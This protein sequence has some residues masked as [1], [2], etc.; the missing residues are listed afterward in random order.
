MVP[1]ARS[2]AQIT[3]SLTSAVHDCQVQRKQ[4]LTHSA[5]EHSAVSHRLLAQILKLICSSRLSSVILGPVAWPLLIP[6]CHVLM[7]DFLC[8]WDAQYCSPVDAGQV[9]QLRSPK[10]LGAADLMCKAS[11]TEP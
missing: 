2:K 5:V 3:V 7:S 8:F 11:L 6:K 10:A 1:L 4:Q 9:H